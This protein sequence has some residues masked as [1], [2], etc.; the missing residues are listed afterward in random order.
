MP[1]RLLDLADSGDLGE[2]RSV[3]A[4]FG[5]PFPQDGSSRWLSGGSTLLDQGIYPVTLA[6]LMLGTPKRI[7]ATG[8]IRP[9][10]VDLR[11]HFTFD[12]PDARFAQGAYSQVDWLDQTGSVS[13]SDAT[14]SLGSGFWYSTRMTLTRIGATGPH[15]EIIEFEREGHGYTPMLR[16]VT[17]AI[18]DGLLEHPHHTAANTHAVFTLLDQIRSTITTASR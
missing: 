4:R 3:Q 13:G 11:G 2:I 8:T 9:D 17:T 12:Y 15:E 10:G 18:R 5:A 16:A 14:V 1:R 7:H 6:H